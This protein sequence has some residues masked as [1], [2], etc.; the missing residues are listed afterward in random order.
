MK[1]L[2]HSETSWVF[3]RGLARGSAHW[4]PFIEHFQRHFPRA[5]VELLD[6]AG[7]GTERDRASFMTIE[8]TLEDMRRRSRFVREGKKAFLFSISLGSMLATEWAQRHPDDLAGIILIN[9]SDRGNSWFFERLRPQTWLEILTI[10]RNP[11][12]SFLRENKIMAI[13]AA[14]YPDADRWA[15]EFAKLPSTTMPNFFRQLYAASRYHFPRAK[16]PVPLLLLASRRDQMVNS[17]CTERIARRWNVAAA[18]HPR[19]G[20]DLPIWAP[21]WVCEKLEE[22]LTGDDKII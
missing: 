16:P 21:E 22:W 1:D 8:D 17:V 9:T 6:M 4:G 7:N 2:R 11:R 3:I 13:T 12:D 20:H 14:G 18:F 15:R 5:Q 19:A 10:L